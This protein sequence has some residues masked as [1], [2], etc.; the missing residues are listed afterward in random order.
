MRLGM[1]KN[2]ERPDSQG[3]WLWLT[4][5]PRTDEEKIFDSEYCVTCHVDVNERRTATDLIPSGEPNPDR[6]FV[7]Y[8]YY[9]RSE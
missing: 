2:A 4:R 8:P 1:V 5:N 6:D 9:S 3:G 7:F